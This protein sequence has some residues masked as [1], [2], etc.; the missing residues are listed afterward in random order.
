MVTALTINYDTPECLERV[1]TSFRK[2]YPDIP[3]MVIDG[4]CKEKYE[5]I[6]DFPKKFN[7]ELIHFD[8]NIH[9]GP[10]LAEGIKR[11]TT[12][13]ILF[14]D[15][16]MIILSGQW[17]E[18]LQ[19]LLRPESYG[20]G[21][22]QTEVC[23]KVQIH[24]LHPALAL[25][26]RDVVLQYPMPIK[27]GAPLLL[28][29]NELH[30]QGKVGLLQKAE[31]LT[32][33]FHHH[34]DKYVKHNHDRMGMGTV[35]KTG[36]YHLD[37]I[38]IVIAT[39]Q[40]PDGKTPQYLE[41]TLSS[42]DRQTYKDYRTFVMGDAYT[43]ENEIKEVIARHPQ[44]VFINMPNSPERERYGHGNMMIW[45]AGGVTAVNKGI[46]IAL[47]EGIAYICHMAHDDTW[48][49]NHLDLIFKMIKKE[50]P[51]FCCTLA[52]YFGT[53]ILPAVGVSNEIQPIYPIDGGMVAS[54]TCVHY[55]DT[56][57]RV[58]DRL[59]EQGIMSP[60]DAYLWEQLRNELIARGR[61]GFITTTITCHH[62]EEGYAIRG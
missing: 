60:C 27:G 28:A 35:S 61:T 22:I 16:D 58:M 39:Y 19:Y 32:N 13:Q 17:L 34:D 2:F 3:Y 20:I 24:Y 18:N 23:E 31:W 25:V 38:G 33:D 55:A 4:S 59:Q 53:Q 54:S 50:H 41:R 40:R 15:S 21:D 30:R 46:S 37:T 8:Y 29:M 1:L 11:I 44:T 56:R 6:K 57:L 47:S 45:C 43:N 42:I 48:E 36:G 62:D 12:E 49:P 10:G 9:H 52:T 51:L 7:I 5:K 26:N 14:M